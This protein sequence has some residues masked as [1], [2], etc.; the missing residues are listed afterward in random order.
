MDLNFALLERVIDFAV[1]AICCLPR[2]LE[3]EQL[4]QQLWGPEKN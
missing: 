1:D 4:T 3:I 2:L